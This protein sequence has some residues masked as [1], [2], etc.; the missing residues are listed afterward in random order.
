MSDEELPALALRSSRLR[1]ELILG[2]GD[3]SAA[4]LE[5]LIERYQVPCVYV[6]GNH[7]PDMTGFRYSAG[8]FVRAG[9]PAEHPGP[10]GGR[11][12]DA[13]VVREAGLAVAGLGG[14]MRYNGGPNQWTE[15]AQARRARRTRRRARRVPSVDVL[16][17]H[18]PAAGIGDEPDG[19]HRGFAC[20]GDLAARLRPRVLLHGHVH[21]H[22]R[23][24][25][26]RGVPL[27]GGGTVPVLNVV[28]YVYLEL[29]PGGGPVTVMERRYG[30]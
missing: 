23:R 7:D 15:R 3:L 30:A 19:A 14:C 21:P 6:P 10:R 24:P 22:G 18:S 11:N 26:D 12:A 2:A 25:P 16:L 5:S 1:P 20:V 17:T 29:P 13:T 9:L 4:Y 27:P 28:G 8:G